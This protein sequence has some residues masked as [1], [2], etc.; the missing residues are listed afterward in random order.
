MVHF[1]V[2]FSGRCKFAKRAQFAGIA[3]QMVPKATRYSAPLTT[4]GFFAR[5]FALFV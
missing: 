1:V 4:F 3:V 2:Q 5:N